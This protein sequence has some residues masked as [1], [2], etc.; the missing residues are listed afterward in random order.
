MLASINPFAILLIFFFFIFNQIMSKDVVKK[1]NGVQIRQYLNQTNKYHEELNS[2]ME[3]E[4][5]TIATEVAESP[6]DCNC[7]DNLE[8]HPAIVRMD[9]KLSKILFLLESQQKYQS[10]NLKYFKVNNDEEL[11]QLE[12][13]LDKDWKERLQI[14]SKL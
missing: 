3:A 5:S 8:K 14:V 9:K 13:V 2:T 12:E 10:K 1:I 4:C 6:T 7:L 11:N